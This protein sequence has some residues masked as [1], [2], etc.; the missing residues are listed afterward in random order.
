MIVGVPREIKPGENRVAM[1]PSGVAAFRAH[2]HDVL[3]ERGAG[4]GS[5]ISD[6]DY[7]QSGARIVQKAE[8]VW[9][10][11]EM[12]VKVKE[13][14]GDEL[15]RMREGQI[16]YTYFH[17]ASSE[18]LTRSLMKNGVSAVAYETI[19]RNDGTLPL[20]TPMSEVA[21]R[22][23]VQK[24]AYCLEAG[25]AGRGILLSGVSG[26]KP[27]HVV[28]LGA[29]TSGQNAC[30]VAVGMGAHVT[31]LD[32]D[33]ARLRYVHD[34]MGGHVTTLMSNRATVGEEVASAD[35]VIGT[36]LIPGARAPVLVTKDMVKAMRPGSA[37]VDVAID[38]GGCCATS[39]PTTH[40]DPIYHEHGVVH[41][42]VTNMPGA[43]PR[44]ATYALTNVTLGY[45]LAL[46]DKG[47]EKAIA[48]D[49]SLHRGLN[50]YQGKI[51][52][53]GVADAFGLPCAEI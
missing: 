10:R 39:R 42:C 8:T 14:F 13:P 32:I 17:L 29:G 27:A 25:N 36:V 19:Q 28:I 43:V 41:Y 31:I 48:D 49:A 51:T 1:L 20:L 26:V 50:V 7:R 5:G 45:G 38:Q 22:L 3:V 15:H 44:T 11:A 2:G 47:L 52:H 35:L 34:I 37:I 9:T 6:A 21:G 23:A 16:V 53:Q 12:V 33:P 4:E 30:H 24:G 46:A 40:D 18:A